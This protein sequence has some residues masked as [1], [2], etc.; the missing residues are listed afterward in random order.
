MRTDRHSI[1]RPRQATP[2]RAHR[3]LAAAHASAAA[4]FGRWRTGPAAGYSSNDVRTVVLQ[5]AL[6]VTAVLPRF[7]H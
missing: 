5:Y 4:G 1:H 2:A 3:P 6:P 7:G